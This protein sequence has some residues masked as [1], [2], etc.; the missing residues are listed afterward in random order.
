LSTVGAADLA[1]DRSSSVARF[2][3]VNEEIDETLE[4]LG[5]N[6]KEKVFDPLGLIVEGKPKITVSDAFVVEKDI[7]DINCMVGLTMFLK[8]HCC[9][10]TFLRYL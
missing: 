9:L 7:P 10:L 5:A 4:Y 1:A 6:M 8:F 3:K 2:R